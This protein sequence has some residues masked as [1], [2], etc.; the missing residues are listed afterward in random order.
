[1][2]DAEELIFKKVADAFSAAYPDGAVYREVVEVPDRFP[3]L[4]LVEIDNVAYQP[5]QDLASMEHHA[6]VTYEINVYSNEPDGGKQA[7]KA[8]MALADEQ[9]QR[10]G[11]TRLICSQIKNADSK[12]YRMT[13]RYRAVISEDYIIYRR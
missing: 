4:T 8:V 6:T 5:S 12:I 2:I 7:C 9:M 3:C 11:F 10:L 13:A 1:M